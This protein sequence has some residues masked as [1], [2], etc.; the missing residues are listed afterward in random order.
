MGDPP[1]TGATA[2]RHPE[3]PGWY[4]VRV[5]TRPGAASLE[6]LLLPSEAGQGPVRLPLPPLPAGIS[7]RVVLVK[8][9]FGDATLA[10]PSGV[11]VPV[12]MRRV[13]RVEAAARML[14]ALVLVKGRSGRGGIVDACVDV[15]AT[16]W[17]EGAVRAGD[18]LLRYYE[19][20]V[21]PAAPPRD[22]LEA[23][24]DEARD[25]APCRLR[26]HRFPGA[27]L[28]AD[29]EPTHD[30]RRSGAGQDAVLWETTGEDPRFHLRSPWG[31]PVAMPA[32]W[33]TV[34]GRI[35]AREGRV[36]A[37]SFYPDYGNGESH[38]EM[39]LLPDPDDEG[40]F[41]RTILLKYPVL[42]LRFDPTT[43]HALFALHGFRIARI[44]RFA[45]LW[46]MLRGVA[47]EGSPPTPLAMARAA[48]DL[49]Q[50][51]ARHGPRAATEA[52][53]ASYDARL[54]PHEV[55]YAEWVRRFDTLGRFELAGLR[56][57]ALGI[58]GGPLVSILVPVY[59]T[60][61]RW[62]RRCLD[63]V[64]RQAYPNWELCIADDASPSPHV[65]RVLAEYQARDPRIRVT[66]RERN[67]H[68]VAASNSA[69]AMARGEFV[70]LLDHDDELRPHALL[71]MVEA[72]QANPAL[73]VLYSDEDKLDAAGMRCQPYFKPDW[74]PDLLLSQ[75]YLCHLA[76]I[77]TARVRAVGGFRAG[78]EG[79]QDH[80][81]FLRCTAGLDAGLI[82][83]V[84]KV[85]YHW[86]AI[87]GST[88]LE[89]GAKDY[90]AAAG[91]RAVRDFVAGTGA[92]VEQL[93]HGHYRIRWPVPDP[94]PKISVIIPTR[95]KAQLLATCVD[96]V[97]QRT[98]YPSVEIV[99]VDNQSVEPA[100]FACFDRFRAAG[101]RVLS[102][103]APFN[104]SAINNWAAA[105][106]DGAL[107]CLLNNDI[108]VIGEDW[109][110]EMAG[111]ALRPG[112]GAVGAMLYYPDDTI[113]HAGVILGV[114]GIANHAYAGQPMG[115]AGHGARALVAQN[116]SAVT[117]AC[118]VV[119]RELYAEV[120]GL[121][122]RLQVAFNDIDLCL[123]LGEAGYRNVWTPFARLYHHESASR[124]EED[125]PGKVRRFLDEV[126]FMERRWGS[127]LRRD[128]A[129]NPNLSLTGM[130]SGLANPPRT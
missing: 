25:G 63:S 96:S 109:L 87:A 23:G 93:P 30:L 130:D 81:L 19:A 68:I 104:Y 22:G 118:L 70:A 39:L 71:E 89:R 44:G 48:M 108:E 92:E 74:N 73:E 91:A 9:A 40:W 84:P 112:I 82:H 99:V 57:R 50:A 67:G 32:G 83:H 8:R 26:R 3:A 62:L 47:G 13:G 12:A 80:D 95:D 54:R 122:E 37:P 86:R 110:E 85:L 10:S 79:S 64:L 120:G 1:T 16:L 106:C 129:Y 51:M 36:V 17:R 105:Q 97:L 56:N 35:A 29:W 111:H 101:V 90:A 38:E 115:H 14:A 4:T 65:R 59:D 7:T 76:V 127:V 114:G 124:G 117:G 31:W 100:T 88:A 43:R 2:Q 21:R 69:L 121:D 58:E 113:Q 42:R 75:N 27:A 41:Q 6:L 98:R 61:E 77:R 107:L 103:D 72:I 45:A 18:L 66:C 94:A 46:S 53:R 128:P 119:R 102:Y 15:L 123:R 125:S 60:P 78:F 11:I 5:A 52:L 33:Y 28:P 24:S 20:E 126:D 55:T 49:L 116:L 34:R